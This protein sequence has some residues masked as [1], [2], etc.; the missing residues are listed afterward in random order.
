MTAFQKVIKYL[1]IGFAIFLIFTI[2]SGITAAISGIGSI[3]TKKENTKII[4]KKDLNSLSSYLDIDL[5]RA[6]LN[7]KKSNRLY[8]EVSSNDIK[9][10][11]KENKVIIEDK[12][13]K[14]IFNYKKETVNLYVPE[15]FKYDLISIDT[16]AGDLNIEY[17]NTKK[18]LLELG[19]GKTVIDSV[20]SDNSKINTGAGSFTINDGQ[21]TDTNIDVGVGKLEVKAKFYGKNKIDTGVG[22]VKLILIDNDYGLH[23][24][25]GIGSITLNGDKIKKDSYYGNGENTID[26]SGGIGSI[27]INV[28]K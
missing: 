17:L 24:D 14:S 22:S 25:K 4:E 15:D 27:N 10:S 9:I 28:L 1:A 26:I 21:L 19:A 12:S 20:Y 8:V 6:T 7:I 16:G 13:K 23:I 5:K 11:E 3:F 2:V 18:L